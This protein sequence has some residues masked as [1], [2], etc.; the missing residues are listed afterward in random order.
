MLLQVN[1]PYNPSC[2]SFGWLV[3]RSVVLSV[4]HSSL[5]S[6]APIGA[7]VKNISDK[8]YKTVTLVSN[9][10]LFFLEHWSVVEILDES[11][12]Y[13]IVECLAPFFRM[14]QPSNYKFTSA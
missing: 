13:D 7:L 1:L 11:L 8:F 2:P 3:G 6:L 4:I 9:I 14:G 10:S 12:V 5:N